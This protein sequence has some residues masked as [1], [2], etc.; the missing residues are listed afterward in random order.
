[1]FSVVITSY[2]SSKYIKKTLISLLN[3]SFKNFEVVLVDDGSTD[4]TISIV[5]KFKQQKKLKI[6]II[7]LLHK[8]S[9]ARSRNVGIL[10][11]KGKYICFLDADDLFLKNKLFEL[12]KTIK[13]NNLDVYYHNVILKHK[14]SNLICKNINKK[15]PFKDLIFNENKIVLSSSCVKKSFLIKKKIKFNENKKLISVEDYDFWL[16]ISRHE[17]SFLL[18]N[19]I[20]GIYNLNDSS[21]SKN[22]YVHFLNTMYLHEKFKKYLVKDNAKYLIK[23]LKIILSFFKISIIEKNYLFFLYLLKDMLKFK[24]FNKYFI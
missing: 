24:K 20:L 13:F 8:G 12:N 16:Q 4:N 22:R 21:I 1:L 10:N 3:Q 11:S 18:I 2:N 19:K 6:K 14:K 23:K 17:G 7:E 5:K 9:P 15:N